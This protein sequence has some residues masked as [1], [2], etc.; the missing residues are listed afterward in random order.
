[1]EGLQLRT[2]VV[3]IPM[4]DADE[5]S[6]VPAVATNV[7]VSPQYFDGEKRLGSELAA[8]IGFDEPLWDAFFF[9]PPNAQL[10]KFDVAI[11]QEGGIVAGTPNSG[12][13]PLPDQSRLVPALRDKVAIIGEQD[14]FEVILKQ[15]TD[16][17]MARHRTGR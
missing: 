16:A 17:F 1:M 9:Y 5:A 14:N 2:Y 8:T 11:M 7:A 15:A 6:E 12:V 10:A 3:W 4:L 13:P